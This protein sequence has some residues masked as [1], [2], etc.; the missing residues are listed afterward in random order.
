MG[1]GVVKARKPAQ[2]SSG[3]RSLSDIKEDGLSRDRLSSSVT[4]CMAV[5]E[6]SPGRPPTIL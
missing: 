6:D 5:S 1:G 3:R 4:V 2:C